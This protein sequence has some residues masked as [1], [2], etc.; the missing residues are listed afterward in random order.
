MFPKQY[1]GEGQVCHDCIALWG[2]CGDNVNNCVK[3]A[4]R[5]V[6]PF[7]IRLENRKLRKRTKMKN[8]KWF[9]KGSL[10]LVLRGCRPGHCVD[11]MFSTGGCNHH[12][13]L[14]GAHEYFLY[15]WRI[16]RH[17]EEHLEEIK[18][19][20]Y[21]DGDIEAAGG[22]GSATVPYAA[23]WVSGSLQVRGQ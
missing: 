19:T 18:I 4:H 22:G 3:R 6:V 9:P 12:W 8:D 11:R 21:G 10:Y 20:S 13:G 7:V 17:R 16:H 1:I 14:I 23:V 2:K 5:P 15:L